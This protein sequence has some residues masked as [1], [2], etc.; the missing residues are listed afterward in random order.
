LVQRLRADRRRSIIPLVGIGAELSTKTKGVVKI[1][2]KPHFKS[3]FEL[4]ISAHVLPKL[5]TLIPSHSFETT[6]WSHLNKLTLADPHFATPAPI[7]IL[8]GA[9]VYGI[10]IKEGLIKRTVSALI[11]Q[12]TSLGWIVSGPISSNI[13][14]NRSLL[15]QTSNHEELLQLMQR[16]WELDGIPDVQHVRILSPDEQS[17]ENHFKRT[18]SRNQDERYVVRLPFNDHPSKLGASKP[19]AIRMVTRLI[20]KFR[21]EPLFANLY[22][23]FMLEY[24][25]LGHMKLV[26]ESLPESSHA[27]YLPHHGVIKESSLTTKLRVVFN[28]SSKTT[29]GMSLNDILFTGPKLQTDLFD[30]L[31]WFRQFKYVFMADME[32]MYRQVRVHPDDGKYQRIL[33]EDDQGNIQ[34]YELQTVTYGLGCAPYLALRA[35]IQLVEDEGDKFPLAIPTLTK[36]RYVDDLFGGADSIK[37]T[38]LLGQEVNKLCM[39]GG[40][41]LQKWASNHT[42]IVNSITAPSPQQST[43]ISIDDHLVIHSLGLSWNLYEDAFEFSFSHTSYETIT[44]RQVLSAIAKLFD[45][46]GLISPIIIKAKILMQELWTLKLGWDTPLPPTIITKW[47]TFTENLQDLSNLKF[48]RWIGFKAGH[49]V[50][51]HGFSDASPQAIA[52]VAYS[53]WCTPTGEIAVQLI[54]SKTKVAPLKRQTI[55]RLEL[56]GAVLLTKLVKRLIQTLN[57]TNPEVF[58]WTDSQVTLTWINNHPSRWKEFVHNRVCYIQ[59]TIPQARWKFV[60][61]SD[62]PADLATRGLTPKQLKEKTLRW[63]GPSWLY[64]ISSEWPNAPPVQSEANILEERKQHVVTTQVKTMARWN[65]LDRYYSNLNRLLR[66]TTWCHRAAIRFKH[67]SGLSLSDPITTAELYTAKKYWVKAVQSEIFQLE[68]KIIAERGSLPASH[69]LAK[70]TPFIDSSGIL[71]VGGRLQASSLSQDAKHPAILPRDSSF[72]QLIIAEDHTRSYHGETQLTLCFIRE[73]FWILGGRAPVRKF[74]LRCVRCSRYR[75]LRAKQLMGQLPKERVTPTRPFL[76]SGVDYAG[77]FSVKIW[78]GKNARTYKAYIVLFVCLA[79]SAVHIELVTDYTAEAFIAAYKRFTGRRGICST[80]LSDC[81][82]N[83]KG[84]DAE[85]KR[86]L[87]SATAESA[88]LSQLLARD[89]TQWKFNP[90]SAPHFGGKWEAGVKSVKFHLKRIVGDTLLTYEEFTTLLTQIEAILNSRPLTSCTEDPEDLN[91]LTPGHFIMGCAPTTI[92]EPSMETIKTSYLSRWQLIRQMTERF[93]TRWSKECLQRYQAIYK[94]TESSQPL[95]EGSIVLIVDERYPP[96]KWPLGRVLKI[97]PGR[98]G[99]TRVV[100]V[101]TQMSTITRPIVKLC[102]LMDNDS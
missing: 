64:K 41:P 70:L 43:S 24:A 102:P 10:I 79:S 96:T 17:C 77:P 23:N 60:A 100:T 69:P 49:I 62:N 45:P 19:K 40:F 87:S 31:I 56:I 9:D 15:H 57:S 4:L 42:S 93:W 1:T 2:I 74:I 20:N 65:L 101:R 37:D 90:S 81:G 46:L 25:N 18:H 21:S 85:L 97:H 33:W 67:Q 47:V 59:E 22:S 48:P 68:F 80:L 82:T 86:L 78:R 52:A 58:L 8:L 7:D 16:F 6:E 76:N 71:R 44:K 84:A 39:A 51:I 73:E 28:G 88:H 35:V 53:R 50:E 27:Y 13:R 83:L 95:R 29:S 34:T 5:T 63:N 36:G 66:I 75:Q 61:G 89:G 92:P 26:P 98:D 72:T 32:K 55:P 54:C 3:C 99:K 38:I 94:W 30:V 11:A 12:S 91:V 14:C